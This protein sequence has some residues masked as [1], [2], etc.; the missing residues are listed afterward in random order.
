VKRA[1]VLGFSLFMLYMVG[2]SIVYAVIGG[3]VIQGVVY[4][5]SL[6]VTWLL[7]LAIVRRV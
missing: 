4:A 5:G 6:I 2:M 7:C 1:S 3:Y